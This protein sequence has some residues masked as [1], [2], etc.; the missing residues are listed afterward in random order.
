M[1]DFDAFVA[2]GV[3]TFD[4]GPESCGYGPAETIVGDYLKSRASAS[5]ARPL[6]FTKLCCVGAEQATP[7]ADWVRGRV[8][9]ALTRLGRP[10][11]LDLLQVYW[12]VRP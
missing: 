6:V 10:P 1:A 3:D 11:R 8:D 9:R 4:M 7:S 5:G 12:C 2:A